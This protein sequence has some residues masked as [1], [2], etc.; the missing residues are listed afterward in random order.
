MILEYYNMLA[1]PYQIT[2]GLTDLKYQKRISIL[3][4]ELNNLVIGTRGALD[5]SLPEVTKVKTLN[6]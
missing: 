2:N 6:Q 5:Y 1:D 3:Q 4:A